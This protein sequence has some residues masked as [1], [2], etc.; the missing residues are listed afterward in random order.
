MGPASES[1]HS[2]ALSRYF[3]PV[4]GLPGAQASPSSDASSSH[5]V[6]IFQVSW[7]PRMPS[8]LVSAVSPVP[9]AHL[10][11]DMPTWLLWAGAGQKAKHRLFLQMDFGG[12]EG[13]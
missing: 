8:S 13:L 2:K 6:V 9:K 11:A 3:I 10:C 7:R 1:P 4:L 12:K 5:W